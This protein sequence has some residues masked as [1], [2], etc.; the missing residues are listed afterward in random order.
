MLNNHKNLK[1]EK[2]EISALNKKLKMANVKLQ[3]YAL[4]IEEVTILKE[5]TRVSQELHDSLGHSLMAL[6]MY[7]E[8]AKK[9]YASNPEK[10]DGVLSKAEEIAKSSITD[11]RKTVSL[12]NSDLEIESFAYSLQKAQ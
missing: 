11:L 5:R 8:Y 7:L 9:T 3:E 2:E 10:L 6:S 4:T 12:L 1:I